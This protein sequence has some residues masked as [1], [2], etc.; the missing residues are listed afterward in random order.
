MPPHALRLSSRMQSLPLDVLAQIGSH[1]P[2]ASPG[3]LDFAVAMGK[4]QTPAILLSL[5]PVIRTGIVSV[6][7]RV[8]A[9]LGAPTRAVND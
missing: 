2:L 9:F 4:E 5:Q 7:R 6:S 1:L 3:M 8:G